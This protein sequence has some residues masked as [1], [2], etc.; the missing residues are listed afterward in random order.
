MA[1]A[2]NN[3]STYYLNLVSRVKGI[4]VELIQGNW[5][6]REVVEARH[7]YWYGLWKYEKMPMLTIAKLVGVKTHASVKNAVDKVEIYLR[8]EKDYADRNRRIIIMMEQSIRVY[9]AGKVSGLPYEAVVKKFNK[10]SRLLIDRGYVPVS[11]TD[12]IQPGTPWGEAMKTCIRE[13]TWCKGIYLLRDYKESPGATLEAS[14]AKQ[15]GIS[16][17]K[18]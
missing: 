4:P 15:L 2:V 6:K 10:A 7:L 18:R 1:Q 17:I 13:L 16:V 11:P 5:R 14:I 8:T 3:K 9:I 12:I